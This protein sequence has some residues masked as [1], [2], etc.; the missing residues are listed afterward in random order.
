MRFLLL[1]IPLLAFALAMTTAKAAT[2]ERDIDYYRALY[3]LAPDDPDKYTPGQ[4]QFDPG[5]VVMTIGAESIIGNAEAAVSTFSGTDATGMLSQDMLLRHSEGDWGDLETRDP[6]WAASQDASLAPTS[7]EGFY[8]ITGIHNI[9]GNEVWVKTTIAP[10]GN[11]TT[12]YLPG[13]D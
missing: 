12:F 10:D 8:D 6:D 5:F 3:R 13:E 4:R 1:A 11:V 9:I 7:T 2:R